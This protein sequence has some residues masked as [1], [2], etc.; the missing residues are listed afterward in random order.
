MKRL[1]AELE[2]SPWCVVHMAGIFLLATAF[3]AHFSTWGAHYMDRTDVLLELLFAMLGMF[4][5][6]IFH[7]Y[8]TPHWA[9]AHGRPLVAMPDPQK[10]DI[11]IECP[12]PTLIGFGNVK[13]Y[14]L[15]VQ[16]QTL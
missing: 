4:S 8:H 11:C 3:A 7:Q 16:T 1:K 5:W 14:A 15:T 13:K 2:G 10:Q 9:T 12:A 6:A